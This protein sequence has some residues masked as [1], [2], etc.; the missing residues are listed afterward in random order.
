M[1]VVIGNPMVMGP[2]GMGKLKFTYTGDYTERE[3][4]VVELRS[5]GIL[6]F[7]NKA[8][9][10]LF[11]VGGGGGGSKGNTSYSEGYGGSGG[12]G[13]YTATYR[14]VSVSQNQQFDVTIGQGG[15]AGTKYSE[16]AGNGGNTSVGSDYT[17]SGGSGATWISN[18][19]T[20]SRYGYHKGGNGGSGGATGLGNSA[21]GGSDG[22]NGGCSSG[23]YQVG[24][25]Q[26]TTTREFGEKT[27]KLY[28]GGGGGGYVDI[29][30]PTGLGGEG[31]GGNAGWYNPSIGNMVPATAGTPNTGGG[32][33]GSANRRTDSLSSTAAAGGS[34]IVCFRVSAE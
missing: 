23:N 11:L 8:V 29:W 6:V 3:D 17:V 18:V 4:G 22:S 15:A 24:I 30:S 33:G 7:L 13:G 5:S 32:G 34:G 25:G 1:S 21:N 19:T 16:N 12:G 10:D 9:I 28:A 2:G 20:Y 26:G 31:G 27:G 14:G